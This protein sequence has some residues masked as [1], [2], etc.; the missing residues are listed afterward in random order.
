MTTESKVFGKER[1]KIA[2]GEANRKRIGVENPSYRVKQMAMD[3][4]SSSQKLIISLGY[5]P[6]PYRMLNS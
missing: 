6:L 4:A 1:V 3:Q 5:L 2:E